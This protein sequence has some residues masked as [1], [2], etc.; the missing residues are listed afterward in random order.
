MGTTAT[1]TATAH[2]AHYKDGYKLPE[3]GDYI[4]RPQN[5]DKAKRWDMHIL[6][7]T[8]DERVIGT[9]CGRASACKRAQALG[10]NTARSRRV[11]GWGLSSTR[12][13]PLERSHAEKSSMTQLIEWT[14]E[15]IAKDRSK[16]LDDLYASRRAGSPGAD[17]AIQEHHRTD[18]IEQLKEIVSESKA[19]EYDDRFNTPAMK[20]YLRNYS[21]GPVR[22]QG[23]YGPSIPKHAY[24]RVHTEAA[25]LALSER[26]RIQRVRQHYRLGRY[27]DETGERLVPVDQW[28]LDAIA[29]VI[30]EFPVPNAR[31]EEVHA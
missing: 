31:S 8:A 28:K 15:S 20:R 2:D 25:W 14:A 30:K 17:A 19:L 5:A 26:K 21:L 1:N 4:V 6:I 3:G 22:I 16:E 10:G 18:Y 13:T 29:A 23:Q 11:R 27:L 12:L 24:R 7:C 9:Y